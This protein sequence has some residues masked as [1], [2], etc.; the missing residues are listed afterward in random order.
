M[1]DYSSFVHGGAAYPLSATSTNSL[2]QDADPAVFF[3]LDY[4]RTVIPLYLG[5]RVLAE[6]NASVPIGA[7]TSVL[8]QWVPYDP[9]PYLQEQQLQFP[10]LAV[11]RVQEQDED[12]TA[13]WPH[14]MCR[15]AAQYI[16]PPLTSGQMQRVAPI[17]KAVGDVLQNR[18]E[19]MF[20]PGYNS[21]ASP[22][23]SAG[24]ESIK[25]VEGSYGRFSDGGNMT[26]PT[27][28]GTLLVKE[29][30]MPSPP[31]A[32]Q[33]FA[34]IDTSE[35]LASPVNPT[36]QDVVDVK[37]DYLDPT[38]IANLSHL[39]RSDTSV[40]LDATDSYH[41]TSWG[42]LSGNNSPLTQATLAS[43]P[44]PSPN[45]FVVQNVPRAA[46]RFDGTGSGTFMTASAT[47]LAV[48][49]GKTYFVL[50]RFLNT[51][52]RQVL[53]A[54]TLTAD[55][56]SHSITIE[57]NTTGGAGGRF[58]LQLGGSNYDSGDAVDQNWHLHT[59]RVTTTATGQ[60]ILGSLT[61]R[62]DGQPVE[63][64]L[65]T[66]GTGNWQGMTTANQLAVGA[67]PA[68][69]P[70]ATGASADEAVVVTYA[71]ALSDAECIQVEQYMR[72]FMGAS[73][74]R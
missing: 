66:V 24:L 15:W 1:A 60:S 36:I 20:D 64:L 34:G 74:T 7:F 54:H 33:P 47:A 39:F 21:G 8:A 6:L 12:R 52:A 56:G 32:F 13:N 27:W 3:A 43:E 59:V 16:L 44:L 67:L 62:I 22:W 35:D 68:L 55:T 5:A 25:L 42:D 41:A 29:R 71:R 18:I 23:K 46:L 30:V 38:K 63:S 26:F 2:L 4:F 40:A 53:F 58:G 19:N 49:T 31:S 73:L 10:L 14:R 45:A 37:V 69:L 65:R 57:A 17:L 11:Y 48:D 28:K 51:T 9:A 61:Y 72:A 50:G 70:S